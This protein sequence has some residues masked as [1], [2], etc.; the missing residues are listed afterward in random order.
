MEKNKWIS[1]FVGTFGLV[2][3]GTG[4]IIINDEFEGVITHPGIALTF[5]LIVM[6]MIYGLGD[7]SGAHLNPAVTLGFWLAQRL[8]GKEIPG[9]WISQILGGLSASLLL[10]LTFPSHPS[11]GSTTPAF[12]V[13]S[14]FIFEVIL[15]FFLMFVI[16][17]VATG[18]KEKGLMAGV[19]IGATV[20]LCALFAGPV[21]GASMNPARSLAPAIFSGTYSHL[22][23]YLTAPF[24]GSALAIFLCR[25]MDYVGCCPDLE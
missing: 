23:I 14:A 4:A 17:H 8:S 10:K 7:I 15:T 9:Y 19:A 13:I 24:I 2:F 12:H 22:W 11:L 6:A 3:A 5:G 16:I 20:A 21:T 18:A 1:E 25:S